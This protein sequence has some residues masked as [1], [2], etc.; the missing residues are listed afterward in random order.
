MIANTPSTTNSQQTPQNP[1][2][3]TPKTTAE[4]SVTDEQPSSESQLPEKHLGKEIISYH[5]MM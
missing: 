3:T 4:P 1:A 5:Q 2:S